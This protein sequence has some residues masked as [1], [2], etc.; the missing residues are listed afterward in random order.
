MDGYVELT[1]W[2]VTIAALLIV[3]NGTISVVLHLRMEKSLAIA[4]LRTLV[5]LSLVGFVLQWVFALDRWYV[6]MGLAC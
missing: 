4:S 1:Y 2:Q 6:V 5:Q 3:I